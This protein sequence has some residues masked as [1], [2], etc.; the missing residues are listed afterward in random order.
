MCESSGLIITNLEQPQTWLTKWRLQVGFDTIVYDQAVDEIWEI[1]K[2][3]SASLLEDDE[4]NQETTL[5]LL[6]TAYALYKEK[7]QYGL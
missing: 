7:N 3:L 2:Y 1:I 6:P 4:P 5:A